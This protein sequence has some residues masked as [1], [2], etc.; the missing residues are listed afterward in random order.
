MIAIENK[1]DVIKIIKFE[2]AYN[3]ITLYNRTP[4]I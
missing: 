2:Q 3:E 1:F 4:S